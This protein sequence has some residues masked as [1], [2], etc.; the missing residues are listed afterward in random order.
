MERDLFTFG[1]PADGETFI[2]R[3]NEQKILKANFSHGINT[4]I[5]SPRRWGKTSLVKK[6]AGE[7]SSPSCPVV[8]VDVF[9]CKSAQEFCEKISSAVLSQTAGKMDEIIENIKTFLN[10]VNISLDMGSD[11]LSSISLSMLLKQGETDWE[12]LLSIPEKIAQKKGCHLV[13]CIDEFQQIAEFEDS[14]TFQRALRT[15]WQHQ[16]NVTYCLFGSKRHTMEHILDSSSKPFYKFGE[17]MYL[18]P[19]PLSYWTPFIQEKF[20]WGGKSI[21]DELCRELCEKVAYNSYYV[22]QLAWY[23]F[24]ISEK[25]VEREILDLALKVLVDQNRGLFESIT[26]N[27]TRIQMNFLRAVSAGIHEKFTSAAV[28]QRFQMGTSAHIIAAKKSLLQKDLIMEQDNKIYL[29]DPVLGL[30]INE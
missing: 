11:P 19:I 25:T 8:F 2:D 5:I 22:Q 15:V 20:E 13:V 6:V 3:E 24:R 27:L 17:L 10:R 29:S 14:D 1:K 26:D 23:T 12:T 21:S 16:K 9:K 28:M 30:W 18:K 7:I 4:I